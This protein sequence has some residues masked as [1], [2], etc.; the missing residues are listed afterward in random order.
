MSHV[1]ADVVGLVGV[2]RPPHLAKQLLVGDDLPRV[3]DERREQLVLDRRQAH[4][5]VADEHLPVQEV[6]PELSDRERRV[7][8]LVR[9]AGGVTERDP[10]PCEELACAEGLAHVIVGAGVEG[11][12]LVAL[13]AP[14]REHDDRD[15]RP[16][17]QPAD[18]V[19]PVDV[20]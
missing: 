4:L 9:R 3:P 11:R 6:H 7:V 5:A 10:D 18:D 19:D 1:H 12:H 20:G 2:R 15:G 17:A 16:L 14:R 8:R 13:L